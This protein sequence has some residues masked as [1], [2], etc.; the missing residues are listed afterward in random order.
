M[1][2]VKT[3]GFRRAAPGNQA[4]GIKRLCIPSPIYDYLGDGKHI[5]LI[6]GI[7]A[8][9]NQPLAV[10]PAQR[11]RSFRAEGFGARGPD[12]ISTWDRNSSVRHPSELR[13]VG[14]V[15]AFRRQ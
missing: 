11:N 3:R 9:E 5:V 13:V 15:H 2:N 14:A 10:V 12:R 1:Q 7:G 8:L 4:V 6:D